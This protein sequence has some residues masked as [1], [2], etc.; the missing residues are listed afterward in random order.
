MGRL[1]PNLLADVYGAL[2]GQL[3]RA[4]ANRI[5]S[6]A[7]IQLLTNCASPSVAIPMTTVSGGLVFAMLHLKSVWSLFV[8]AAFYGC[9]F[10]AYSVL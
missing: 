6:A 5:N 9:E 8:F 10:H 7:F 2:N 1:V 4:A 3:G